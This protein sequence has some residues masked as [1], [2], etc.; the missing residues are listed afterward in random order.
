[1]GFAKFYVREISKDGKALNSRKLI[2]TSPRCSG[3]SINMNHKHQGTRK[4]AVSRVAGSLDLTVRVH[5]YNL[6]GHVHRG[7]FRNPPG[8]IVL[9]I[10]RIVQNFQGIFVGVNEAEIPK[11]GQF[12]YFFRTLWGF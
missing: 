8:G 11:I 12:Q 4:Q 5:P 7:G 3:S 1:M 10:V 6:T 9:L 2:P